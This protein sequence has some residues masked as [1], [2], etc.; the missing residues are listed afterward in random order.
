MS[1]FYYYYS[2]GRSCFDLR[3]RALWV[4]KLKNAGNLFS[5]FLKMQYFYQIKLKMSSELLQNILLGNEI[6]K[7]IIKFLYDCSSNV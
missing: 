6:F 5:R 1:L 7:L 3:T 2:Q 4:L